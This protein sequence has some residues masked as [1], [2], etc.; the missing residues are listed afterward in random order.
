MAQK[1]VKPTKQSEEFPEA[2]RLVD[3]AHRLSG[4]G[5]SAYFQHLANQSRAVR[6]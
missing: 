3:M 6:G 5:R 1:K 2:Q 4:D